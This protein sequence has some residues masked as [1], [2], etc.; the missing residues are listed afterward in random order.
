MFKWD[1]VDLKT[2]TSVDRSAKSRGGWT[3]ES[4]FDGLVRRLLHA[5][6]TNDE[7]TVVV[8]GHSAAAGHGN[9][10]HQNYAHRVGA[11]LPS[12][13]QRNFLSLSFFLPLFLLYHSSFM[14]SWRLSLLG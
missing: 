4:S 8:G 10:F 1:I 6:M 11:K 7:F 12:V 5:I 9:H 14:L 13:Y 3:T 2:T